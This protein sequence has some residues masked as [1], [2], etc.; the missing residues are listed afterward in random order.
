MQSEYTLI[1]SG[2]MVEVHYVKNM[3]QEHGIGSIIKDDHGSGAL[4]G[5]FGGIPD[6]LDLFVLNEDAEKAAALITS[7]IDDAG[8]SG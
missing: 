6:T 1:F 5:F 4:A 3:L 8:N 2:S 7:D